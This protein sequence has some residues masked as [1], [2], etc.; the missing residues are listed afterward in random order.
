LLVEVGLGMIAPARHLLYYRHTGKPG[1][2]IYIRLKS[3][4]IGHFREREKSKNLEEL[5]DIVE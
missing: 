3:K 5:V 2:Y 4:E 1:Y